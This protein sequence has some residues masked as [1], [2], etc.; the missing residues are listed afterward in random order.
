MFTLLTLKSITHTAQTAQV[1]RLP[2]TLMHTVYSPFLLFTNCYSS[3]CPFS[4]I[5]KRFVMTFIVDNREENKFI[6]LLILILVY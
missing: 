1:A 3:I 6:V 5:F 4:T 2:S